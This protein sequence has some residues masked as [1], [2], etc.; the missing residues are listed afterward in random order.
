MSRQRYYFSI[1]DFAAARGKDPDLAF[2]G[3]SP[4]ALADALQHALRTP[5][6]F[7][8]WRAKQED[9][10]KVDKSLA[11]VDAQ[12]EVKAEQA[13]LKVDMQVATD[14]PMR[15]LRQRMEWLIGNHWRLHD[16]R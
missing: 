10:D 1:A 3:R 2:E 11:V 6:L 4:D 7:E 12:A 15:V 13:D 9:P 16:V 8:R 14:L 5:D